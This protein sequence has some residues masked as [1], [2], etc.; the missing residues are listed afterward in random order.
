MSSSVV[1]VAGDCS[2]FQK[3]LTLALICNT[4]RLPNSKI[5]V[6]SICITYNDTAGI[7]YAKGI[8]Q[9]VV[10]AGDHTERIFNGAVCHS[11]QS[12]GNS[13]GQER[14]W[15]SWSPELGR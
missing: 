1:N 6:Q 7:R 9:V 10:G 14:P 8:L 15:A 5:Q 3:R 2:G 4:N 13:S 11:R 12:K